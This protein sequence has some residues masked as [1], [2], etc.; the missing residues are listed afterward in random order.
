MTHR[1]IAFE[2]THTVDK[3]RIEA[4]DIQRSLGC[5]SC[6]FVTAHAI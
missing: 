3:S 5:N 6:F 1:I 2:L 4:A